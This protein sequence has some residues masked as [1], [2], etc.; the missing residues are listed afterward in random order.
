[1]TKRLL[2]GAALSVVMED[3]PIIVGGTAEEY[4]SRSEY[5]PTDLDL[6]PDPSKEDEKA[7]KALGFYR[8]GRHWVRD[9][10]PFG[11]EFP[12]DS[13]FQV[14]RTVTVKLKMPKAEVQ[15]IGVDDLFLDRLSQA[16]ATMKVG[17]MHFDS[18]LAVAVTNWDDLDRVYITKRIREIELQNPALGS[19]MRSMERRC[20]R[21]VRDLRA[22]Q[23]ATE[24][25]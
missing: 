9:E 3:P 5:H 1:M 16:T 19:A 24:L 7:F 23:R 12:H 2:V 15:M 14:N 22:R 25:R 10:V 13:T 11:I 4:W 21:R 17:D 8:E 20:T 6:I 18:L